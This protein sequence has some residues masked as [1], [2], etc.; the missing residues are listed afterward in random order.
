MR[1][2]EQDAEDNYVIYKAIAVKDGKVSPVQTFRWH[3]YRPMT[4][5]FQ[6]ELVFEKTATNPV[7]YQI[8]RDNES[9]RAMA[10]YIEGEESGI[11][12]D[13]LQTSADVENLKTYLDENIAT[14]P[15]IVII[16]HEHGDHDA[17]MPNFINAGI[18]VYLNKRGWSAVG[19]PGLVVVTTQRLKQ[20]LRM[21]KKE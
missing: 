17:Q 15:Y 3:L 12:Y 8:F 11:L 2:G 5:P 4:G 14:K 10:W 21:L 13:A 9:V 18:D 20:K 1:S 16:G 6:H 19:K 7:V